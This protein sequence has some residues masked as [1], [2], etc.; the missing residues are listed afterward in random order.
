MNRF[1]KVEATLNEYETLSGKFKDMVIA[2]NNDLAD[3]KSLSII[4][5]KD[6]EL[7]IHLFGKTIKIQFSMVFQ[8][9]ENPL[10]QISAILVKNKGTAM[11]SESTI[12]SRWF[13]NLGNIRGPSIEENT[14]E[15]IAQNNYLKTFVYNVLD[16]LLLSENL[17]PSI[18]NG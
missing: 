5:E 14:S 8:S 6:N 7:V 15:H 18:N 12:L 16:N 10:G 2:A 11:E 17:K 13:D 9:S 1:Q 3:I 4:E